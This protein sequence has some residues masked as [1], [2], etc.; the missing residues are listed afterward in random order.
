MCKQNLSNCFNVIINTITTSTNKTEEAGVDF[1]NWIARNVPNGSVF[2]AISGELGAGK[3]TFV[4]GMASVLAPNTHIS[5]PSYT[6]VNHYPASRDVYHCDLYR[7]NGEDDLAS[8]GFYDFID[9]GIVIA[10]WAS[11]AGEISVSNYFTVDIHTV[12]E[13]EREII[14]KEQ[15]Q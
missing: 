10:E 2:V 5:S 1:A 12:N 6:I 13:N 11:V 8:V 15:R 4:R 14:I 9:S 3:T 7:I